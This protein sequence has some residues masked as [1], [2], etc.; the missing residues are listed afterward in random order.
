M[1]HATFSMQ[2][3]TDTMQYAACSHA[4]LL[5]SEGPLQ[6]RSELGDEHLLLVG[7]HPKLL[8]DLLDLLQ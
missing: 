5:A 2:H 6:P 4:D 7:I 1:Q 3:T 8:L